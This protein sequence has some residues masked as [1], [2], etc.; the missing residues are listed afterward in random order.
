MPS[1]NIPPT[2]SICRSHFAAVL[3]ETG[4]VLEALLEGRALALGRLLMIFALSLHKGGLKPQK[5]PRPGCLLFHGRTALPPKALREDCLLALRWDLDMW[6]S[7]SSGSAQAPQQFA[8]DSAW[9]AQLA[10]LSKP[11]S[12]EPTAAS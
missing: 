5:T 10:K 12:V 7:S 9:V 1:S 2:A 8:E 4:L 3:R 11:R 6:N